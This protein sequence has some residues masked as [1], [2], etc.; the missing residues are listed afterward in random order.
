[1]KFSTVQRCFLTACVAATSLFSQ[2]F[3]SGS[4][5]SDGALDYTGKSG[6]I[7]FDPS[8]IPN[9]PAENNV[10]NFTTITIPS[11]LTV[12][13]SQ[14]ILNGPV[15]WLAQGPVVIGGTLDLSGS[16][17]GPGFPTSLRV[18]STPG[19][20]G[21]PGGAA[22][23]GSNKPTAGLG[24][25][26]G[27]PCANGTNAQGGTY[28][29]NQFAIPLVG[30]SGGGGCSTGGGAGG[31]AILIA[32]SVSI[33]NNNGNIYAFG[34]ANGNCD[35]G[36]GSGGAVRL[37]A[38]TVNAGAI[39][40]YGGGGCVGPAAGGGAVRIESFNDP[41]GSFNVTGNGNNPRV[42]VSYGS[43]FNTFV[44]PSL[45]PTLK[46]LSVGGVPVA[47]P[48]TGSFTVPDVVINTGSPVTVQIQGTQIP[49]NTTVTLQF[50]SDNGPD[51][52]VT[53]TLTGTTALTTANVQ[54]TFPAG[55]TR[56]FVSA[57]F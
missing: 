20:G 12:R 45:V 33:N 47:S 52:T 5:G 38:P 13:F 16:N 42:T 9:H 8:T 28:T 41:G 50:F 31:G 40:V 51:M 37:V 39:Y 35:T 7:N 14:S 21:Y 2:S 6:T 29:G 24:P 32:S 53:G 34:G 43:P 30:G 48:A 55:Y 22:A 25:G 11:G 10:F 19:A 44:A 17:G 57:S 54:F 56:G 18:L 49:N 4:D 27:A 15:I 46:V 36:P 3:T 23:S 26:G 1:M